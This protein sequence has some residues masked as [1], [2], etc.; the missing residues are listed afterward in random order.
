MRQSLLPAGALLLDDG[1]KEVLAR[2]FARRDWQEWPDGSILLQEHVLSPDWGRI[3]DRWL[4]WR[5][6]RWQEYRSGH[7]LYAASELC[8][9]L[10]Q[11][12]F[13]QQQVYGSFEGTPYDQQ[14]RRLVLLAQ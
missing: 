6:E 3:D 12:G 2:G 10:A 4:L 5:N 7:R 8:A 14:A 1:G 13:S 11:A 9:L